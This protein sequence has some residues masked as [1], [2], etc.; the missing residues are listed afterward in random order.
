L[1]LGL[2]STKPRTDRQ[3]GVFQLYFVK[4]DSGNSTRCKGVWSRR[5][6]Q[7]IRDQKSHL[8]KPCHNASIAAKGGVKGGPVSGR[9][10][11]K[12]GQFAQALQLAHTPEAYA[13]GERTRSKKGVLAFT[14]KV[15]GFFYKRCLESYPDAVRWKFVRVTGNHTSIDIYIPSLDAYIEVDGVYWHGLDRPYE[16]LEPRIRAK[17]DR[18]RVLDAACHAQGITLFRITDQQ[19]RAKDW[20]W[21]FSELQRRQVQP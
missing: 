9:Q 16:E 15:E 19:V 1:I 12:T 20:G 10:A 21:L 3:G 14:S 8:C 13:K 2:A 7:K 5:L 6:T 4:C 11:V 18:D 17:Y